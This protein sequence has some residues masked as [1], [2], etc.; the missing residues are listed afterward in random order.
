M[1]CDMKH[2]YV[3]LLMLMPGIGTATTSI[4]QHGFTWHF[5]GD[6]EVGRYA[7]GDYWVLGP[8]RII[9]IT[10]ESEDANGWVKHGTQVN[11][12]VNR[13]QG[14]DSSIMRITYDP[15]L[16]VSPAI[17]RSP[18]ELKS[19]SV[20]SSRSAVTPGNIPQLQSAAILTV[21]DE[22]PP[23]TAFRPP[24]VGTDKS[25]QWRAD[26][27]H[28][29]L[30]RDL[31]KVANM[32]D[33][34][35]A[36]DFFERPW[37][38][39]NTTW[40]GRYI[41]PSENQPDYGREI[42]KRLAE[43]LLLLHL[44]INPEIKHAL[45]I[46]LVQYGLDVYGSARAGGVWRDNGGHN[47]GR[48]MPMVLAGLM[49]NDPDIIRLANAQEHFIFAEDRQTWYVTESDVGRA[50]YTADGRPR[51]P[52]LNA[53]IG[54]AEWGERHT[55]RP[56]RD[57]RNWDA[58]YRRIVGSS[59]VGHTLTAHLTPGALDAWKWPALFDYMDRFWEREQH[60]AIG[61]TNSISRFEA[62]MWQAYRH[63]S[64]E[65]SETPKPPSVQSE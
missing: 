51:V 59:V 57:G 21:V 40:T 25:S 36:T 3:T 31:P 64:S 1:V 49:L 18:L 47:H 6:Y 61:S 9:G 52:Y 37:I 42:A 5:D 53:D 28:K 29:E 50:L 14:F 56:E 58:Y 38:E 48:K 19:G 45:L 17:T 10:P 12:E 8:V 13:S 30:L 16:N 60:N 15:V 4:T 63:L 55:L 46:G 39:L 22:V 20:V 54:I 7:N 24:P 62:D 34:D 23:P 11:P 27:L 2:I 43:G 32:P 41:H 44:D 33:P 65:Q 26:A 35:R